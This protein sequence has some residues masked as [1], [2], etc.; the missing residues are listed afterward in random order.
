MIDYN[1]IANYFSDKKSDGALEEVFKVFLIEDAALPDNA[2]ETEFSAYRLLP[3]TKRDDGAI[4]SWLELLRQKR[5]RDHNLPALA[6]ALAGNI[7]FIRFSWLLRKLGADA[8]QRYANLDWPLLVI[9]AIFGSQARLELLLQYYTPTE[10]EWSRGLFFALYH[11]NLDLFRYMLTKA[12]D[13]RRENHLPE[14]CAEALRDSDGNSLLHVAILGNH[15]EVVDALGRTLSLIQLE[16]RNN[17][18]N[19]AID[20]VVLAGNLTLFRQLAYF[21][22]SLGHPLDYSHLIVVLIRKN[23]FTEIHK[24]LLAFLKS[25][26]LNDIPSLEIWIREAIN[27]GNEALAKELILNFP[28]DFNTTPLQTHATTQGRLEIAFMLSEELQIK[29]WIQD[30]FENVLARLRAYIL[31]TSAQL[32]QMAEEDGLPRGS[33][34]ISHLF[35]SDDRLAKCTQQL[36]NFFYQDYYEELKEIYRQLPTSDRASSVFFSNIT[37]Q[38]SALIK[39]IKA[40]NSIGFKRQL[41][42]SILAATFVLIPEMIGSPMIDDATPDITTMDS[43]ISEDSSDAGLGSFSEKQT[44]FI[45]RFAEEFDRT[46]SL[47]E[48]LSRGDVVRQPDAMTQLAEV[49]RTAAIAALPSINISAPM[50]GVPLPFSI[51]LP[52]GVAVAAVIDL[53]MYIR[54]EMQ[55]GQARRIGRFFEGTTMRDR[56]NSIYDCAEFLAERFSDQ[57]ALLSHNHSIP[58]LADMAVARIFRHAMGSDA[59]VQSRTRSSVFTLFRYVISPVYSTPDPSNRRHTLIQVSINALSRYEHNILFLNQEEEKYLTP[60]EQIPASNR[61][62][63]WTVKGIFEHT[64]IRSNGRTYA[65]S[66]QEIERFGYIYSTQKEVRDRGMR[67]TNI[68]PLFEARGIAYRR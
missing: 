43:T 29:R 4:I 7:S 33:Y 51:S 38:R 55:E 42:E 44:H 39:K 36:Q 62:I 12:N 35:R 40:N 57:I 56:V 60:D 18:G 23:N 21:Y 3:V 16:L 50:C 63:D 54:R 2:L 49:A 20:E 22:T 46:Y 5:N 6:Y 59:H 41:Q 65:G 67:P 28:K 11:G 10:Q 17:D 26:T 19:R 14:L 64:G 47:Y 15:P 34:R 27:V 37:L 8:I 1:Q 45:N 48:S 25:N 13:V 66:G 31:R 61:P 30:I 58:R 24:E 32:D 68:V 53:F 9:T 52:S